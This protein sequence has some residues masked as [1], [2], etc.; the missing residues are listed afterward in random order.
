MSY[1][2]SGSSSGMGDDYDD[3]NDHDFYPNNH[4][5]TQDN[6]RGPVL[7]Q[8]G[9][10][11]FVIQDPWIPLRTFNER[12]AIRLRLE[13]DLDHIH[14][15]FED[16]PLRPSEEVDGDVREYVRLT[17]GE[18]IADEAHFEVIQGRVNVNDHET[19]DDV[20]TLILGTQ[21][22]LT[23]PSN[24]E[25]VH[26]MYGLNIEDGSSVRDFQ[27]SFGSPETGGAESFGQLVGLGRHSGASSEAAD[28]DR[29]REG[30]DERSLSVAQFL[31]RNIYYWVDQA[32]R[33]EPGAGRELV[34]Q[35]DELQDLG[36]DGCPWGVDAQQAWAIRPFRNCYC[37]CAV[38]RLERM[39]ME[40][41]PED[42]PSDGPARARGPDWDSQKRGDDSSVE[43]WSSSSAS[44]EEQDAEIERQLEVWRQRQIGGQESEALD[45]RGT[46]GEDELADLQRFEEVKFIHAR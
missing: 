38:C 20:R 37:F 34:A 10:P 7:I 6:R 39:E 36:E 8:S 9:I 18:E 42:S 24:Q 21:P 30:E 12:R 27:D 25:F 3:S 33:S 26:M 28:I 4:D 35:M 5:S 45:P 2:S 1:W 13:R 43:I 17:T 11:G 15:Q 22:P 31:E 16:E 44:D 40:E 23:G 29:R 41:Y 19:W 14:S 46:W 32:L